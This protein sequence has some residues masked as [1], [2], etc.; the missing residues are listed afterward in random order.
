MAINDSAVVPLYQQV[1]D[2]IRAAIESGKYKTNEKIP[3]EPELSA[4]YS[5]SRIT[6]R[7]A[8]S[9]LA[10]AGYIERV[11]GKGSFVKV[12]KTNMQLNHLQGFSEEMKAKGKSPSTQPISL[13]VTPCDR[14]VATRLELEEDARVTSIC[15]LRLADGEPVAVEHVFIPFYLCPQLAQ[16]DGRGS[17]YHQLAEYGLKVCRATQDISA[18]FTPRGVCD[19]LNIPPRTPTLQIERVTYLENNTP[20]EFVR[21][22][23]RSD[24]YTFH[25]E[26]SR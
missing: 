23:Y 3:P 21:S 26:M 15:R 11:Q 6:V 19:L 17:L 24:R 16:W 14:D 10:Q 5:V 9:E 1:K 22:V 12:Q 20:L 13:E 8:M 4:E 7:Q 25:V 2:D 18:G